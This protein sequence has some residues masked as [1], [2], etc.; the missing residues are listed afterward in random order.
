MSTALTK[1]TKMTTNS[2]IAK[3]GGTT[4]IKS[5]REA[6]NDAIREEMRRDPTVIVL[7]EEVSGGA[8]C[9]GQVLCPNLAVSG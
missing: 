8:G 6:L 3:I 7:G 5:Y 1:G 9:D 2:N 4:S